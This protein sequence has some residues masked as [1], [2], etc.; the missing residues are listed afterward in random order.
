V[1]RYPEIKS[2]Q[3]FMALQDELAGTE[4]RIA[5]ERK[6][7]N[8]A[9]RAYNVFVRRF[10]TTYWLASSATRARTSTSRPRRGPRRRRMSTSA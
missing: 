3:N 1:E 6:R 4:N 8:D 7:Y 10:P 5:V 2:N 9:V